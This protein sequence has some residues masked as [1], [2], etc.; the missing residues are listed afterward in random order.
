MNV[1][2]V[3]V[4]FDIYKYLIDSYYQAILWEDIKEYPNN[5]S[6][7]HFIAGFNYFVGSRF[8]HNHADLKTRSIKVENNAKYDVPIRQANYEGTADQRF[9]SRLSIL[10]IIKIL[11]YR[12]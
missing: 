4:K 6:E 10:C 9:E 12:Y 7:F 8:T 3:N 5:E 11:D 1:T 2:D